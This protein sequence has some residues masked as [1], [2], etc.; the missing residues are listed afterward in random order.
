MSDVAPT[1]LEKAVESAVVSALS[2]VVTDRPVSG[3]W[4]P[5]LVDESNL[6]AKTCV[7]VTCSPRVGSWGSDIVSF[8]VEILCMSSVENDLTGTRL[9]SAFCSIV[10]LLAGWNSDEQAAAD[11][12]SI[13]GFNA[14]GVMISGG[15]KPG[16]DDALEV[17]FATVQI[18]IKGVME[19]PETEG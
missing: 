16:A 1:F 12:L 8:Q 15:D 13:D 7:E 9:S 17:W 4:S 6:D 10:N 5:I 2:T 3:F 11:A 14:Q 18:E 19:T